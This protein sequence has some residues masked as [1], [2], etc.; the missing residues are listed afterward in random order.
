MRFIA[1]L[2]EFAG[3][4]RE[5]LKVPKRQKPRGRLWLR[6][7][8]RNHV[9]CCDFVSA[10]THDGRT[11]RVLNLIDQYTQESLLAQSGNGL[12]AG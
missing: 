7:M 6:P 5:G 8:H 2:P 4:E 3:A 11:A 10:R 1:V 9:W 12:M